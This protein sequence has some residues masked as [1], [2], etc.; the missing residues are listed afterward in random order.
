VRGCGNALSL[1]GD[2]GQPLAHPRIDDVLTWL[3]LQVAEHCGN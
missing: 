3:T 1:F 2:Q